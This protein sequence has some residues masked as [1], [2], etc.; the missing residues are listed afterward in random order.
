MLLTPSGEHDDSGPQPFSS[1]P[2]YR[3]SHSMLVWWPSSP[4]LRK[5]ISLT[6][7]VNRR[8]HEHPTQVVALTKLSFTS[9]LT[10]TGTSARQENTSK[11]CT[12]ICC[13]LAVNADMR[14]RGS[15]RVC[16]SIANMVGYTFTDYYL[17]PQALNLWPQFLLS[18]H[19]KYYSFSLAARFLSFAVHPMPSSFFL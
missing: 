7:V 13:S 15:W 18:H 19:S 14:R 12:G 11:W 2:I 3:T 5:Q 6:L 9:A 17:A 1:S 8:R 10:G 4:Q 16:A